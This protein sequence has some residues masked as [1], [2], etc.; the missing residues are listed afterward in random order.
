MLTGRLAGLHEGE[1]IW[2]DTSG[3]SESCKEGLEYFDIYMK[4]YLLALD[5]SCFWNI[6]KNQLVSKSQ[7]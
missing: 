4:K 5:F 7:T 2:L 6:F 3:S 1:H